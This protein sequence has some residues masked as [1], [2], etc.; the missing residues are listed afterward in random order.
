MKLVPGINCSLTGMS[1]HF[2]K[3]ISTLLLSQTFVFRRDFLADDTTTIEPFNGWRPMT[4]KQKTW[5]GI[6]SAIIL[7][8]LV[9]APSWILASR[10]DPQVSVVRELQKKAFSRDAAPE[11]RRQLFEQMRSEGEKLTEEQRKSLRDEAF[12]GRREHMQER[13]T[14]YFNLNK[15]QRVAY[16]DEQIDEMEQ[17]R[18]DREKQ[19][20]ERDAAGGKRGPGGGRGMG[21]RGGGRGRGGGNATPEQRNER[22]R[23]F[24]SHTSAQDRAQ[25][26]A[27]I[28]DLNARRQERGLDP[29]GRG[30][31]RRSA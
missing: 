25:F 21:G 14:K 1:R 8:L 30:G 31:F 17:R 13:M 23:G 29:M 11:D 9:G 4:K 20:K 26:M 28:E 24:L 6:S 16:L 12:A 18:K 22:R 15:E 5:L 7:L 10:E 2:D 19:P 3:R 27:Y